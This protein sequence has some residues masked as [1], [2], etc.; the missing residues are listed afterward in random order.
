MVQVRPVEGVVAD[1]ADDEF[2]LARPEFVH[3][4]PASGL[5]ADVLGPYVPL[6]VSVVVGVLGEDDPHFP[7]GTPTGGVVALN[8][9]FGAT[10]RRRLRSSHLDQDWSFFT[11]IQYAFNVRREQ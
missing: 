5:L 2:A 8:D 9:P 6:R 7:T 4:S 1:L 10:R 11:L 3:Y